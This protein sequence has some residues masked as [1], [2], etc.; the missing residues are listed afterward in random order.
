MSH[1]HDN[2]GD[3][4]GDDGDGDGDG[5][6]GCGDE[7]EE[8]DD[9]NDNKEL[10]TTMMAMMIMATTTMIIMISKLRFPAGVVFMVG[11]NFILLGSTK[12][13]AILAIYADLSLGLP[14]R[15]LGRALSA[16]EDQVRR[17]QGDPRV[18]CNCYINAAGDEMSAMNGC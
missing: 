17:L 9:D 7:E 15:L 18:P 4:D 8:V 14:A 6:C 13:V 10:K 3:V 11:A 1:A 5:G 16:A 2:D 12:V